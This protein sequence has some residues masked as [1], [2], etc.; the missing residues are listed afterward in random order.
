MYLNEELQKKWAP[1]LNHKDLPEID[2]SHK[3]AVIATLLENQEVD[4]QGGPTGGYEAPGGLLAEAAPTNSMGSSSSTAGAGSV[5]IFDPILIS[6]LR[7]A[8]PNLI[9]FDIMGVQPM[10]GPTGLVFA[11]RSRYSTQAGTEA[12][13]NEANTTFSASAAGNSHSLDNANVQTGSTPAGATAASYTAGTPMTTAEAEALG[14][15]ATNNAFQEMAFSIEKIAVTARSRALKAEYSMELAQDLKAVHGLDAESELANIL[16]TE[17]L[18]EINREMVRKI[19]ISS[20]IGAQENVTTAGI[21]DLDTDANGRWMVEKFKGLMFQLER[22]ANAIAKATRR[23]K[24]NI[25]ITSSDV[26][27]ALN[28]AGVLDTSMAIKNN[29]NVDDT[30]NTF[31]GILNGQFK[32]YIDPYFAATSGQHYATVGY[33]GSSAFDAGLFYCPYVP[34]QM[35]RAIGEQTFQPKI[36]F[37]TRYGLVANPFA[38]SAADGVVQFANKNSYYRIVRIDNLM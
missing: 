15:D 17:I 38:T 22:E 29:L 26:A 28:M 31:A 36:G 32:L 16:S 23:G 1:V 33:K 12:L 9:A 34:L 18:A 2:T 24:G 20:T 6:L 27:S 11:M 30:G 13:F 35:V 37:K 8:A 7:R 4:S 25:I 21:F 14:D 5:D 19:N 3:R 10:T